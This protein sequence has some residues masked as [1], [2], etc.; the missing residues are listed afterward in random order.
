MDLDQIQ[1][2]PPKKNSRGISF[3]VLPPSGTDLNFHKFHD[4]PGFFVQLVKMSR[5]SIDNVYYV[6]A[7]QATFDFPKLPRFASVKG[8]ITREEVR[9]WKNE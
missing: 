7:R 5:T 8:Y 6:E 3:E 9:E 2:N 4:G 1:P